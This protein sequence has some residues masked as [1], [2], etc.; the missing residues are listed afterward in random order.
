M[1]SLIEWPKT[2]RSAD[3]SRSEVALKQ[4]KYRDDCLQLHL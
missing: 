1:F 4:V 3:K 2:K